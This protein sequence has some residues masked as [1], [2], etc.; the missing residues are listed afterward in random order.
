MAT[1]LDMKW[2]A[3]LEKGLETKGG[4]HE[5]GHLLEK[6]LSEQDD[7]D[8]IDTLSRHILLTAERFVLKPEDIP[9]PAYVS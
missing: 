9:L 3:D 8:E 1:F 5:V 2:K 7:G 4:A 6:T